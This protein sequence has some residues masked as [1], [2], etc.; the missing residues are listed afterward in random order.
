MIRMIF[1]GRF[2]IS[3][4][5]F[6]HGLTSHGYSYVG[7]KPPYG[8]I[9]VIIQMQQWFD[10]CLKSLCCFSILK[11]LKERFPVVCGFDNLWVK[12][13]SPE[14]RHTHLFS[15]CL[16][17]TLF[18]YIS[19]FPAMGANKS[20][21]VLHYPNYRQVH[22]TAERYRFSHIGKCYFLRCCYDDSPVR[23]F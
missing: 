23:F 10:D 8:S 1:Q 6:S 17:A 15:H 3:T 16:T 7:T 14:E 13:Y 12:G 22:M 21:H 9:S 20:A 5:H 2:S 18:K 19:H 11:I 4:F